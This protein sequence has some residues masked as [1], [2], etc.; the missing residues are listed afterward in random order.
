MSA[1]CYTQM[2]CFIELLYFLYRESDFGNHH[3][4]VCN[5]CRCIIVSELS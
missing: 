5:D 1:A 4:M 3:N 2:L